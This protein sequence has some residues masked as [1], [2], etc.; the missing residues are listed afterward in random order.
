M[1][2]TSKANRNYHPIIFPGIT[3]LAR[4]PLPSAPMPSPL[5]NALTIETTSIITTFNTAVKLHLAQDITQAMISYLEAATKGHIHAKYNYAC[6]CLESSD[7]GQKTRAFQFFEQANNR[8]DPRAAYGVG[9][10]YQYGIGVEPSETLAMRYYTI[11]ATRGYWVAEYLV[12]Y[13]CEHGLGQAP[14]LGQAVTWYRKAAEHGSVQAEHALG[15]CYEHGLGVD[16][17]MRQAIAW[18]RRAAVHGFAVAQLDLAEAYK[19]GLLDGVC[20]IKQAQLWYSQAA[21]QKEKPDVQALAQYQLHL[22]EEATPLPVGSSDLSAPPTHCS[23]F[24][25]PASESSDMAH[26][27]SPSVE[28]KHDAVLTIK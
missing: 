7:A 6:C 22:M 11:A 2:I 24:A 17:D 3:V 28:S 26:Q 15:C 5:L 1:W 10:C 12:G 20:D 27:S 19:R 14:D 16:P 25:S 4:L 23:V 18:Y 9:Y 8:G 13:C 21:E